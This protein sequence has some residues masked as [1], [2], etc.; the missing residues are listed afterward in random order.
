MKKEF[1]KKFKHEAQKYLER[2]L[3]GLRE[4]NPGQA[5]KVLKR[6]G[7]KPGDCTDLSTFSLPVFESENLSDQQ[8]AERLAE[9]FAAISGEFPPL[10]TNA[11]PARV[12]EKLRSTEKPPILTEY[13]V[14]CKIRTAKK[15]R[16]GVPGDFP[17]LI[18]QEF[19]PELSAPVSRIINSM[20]QSYEWPEHWKIENVI[21][22][23]KTTSPENEDDIRPISLTP[24]YSKVAEHFVVSWL[25]N[26]IGHKID[27]RQYG[28]LKGNSITHYIIEFVNF[29]LSCQDSTEQ[30]AVLACMVDFSKAFNR[31]NHNNLITKLS[32]LD[33]PSWLLKIVMAFLKNR[34]SWG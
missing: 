8:A 7:A 6:L 20:F 30:T 2:N 26:S 16:S 17:K 10:A 22:I 28:G 3:E 27:F 21:P 4:S 23:A 5:F 24:F 19:L 25:L 12:Q 34:T 31:Q 13:D 33:V 11:L 9:Y 1:D 14:Y 32:D 18:T 15:P 29:I